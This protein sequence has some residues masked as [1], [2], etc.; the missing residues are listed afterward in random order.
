MGFAGMRTVAPEGTLTSTVYGLIR[1]EKYGEATK[2]LLTQLESF[3]R[4]RAALSLLGYCLYMQADF[5]SAAQCY[6]ELNKFY[7]EVESY[8]LYY[9]QCLHRAGLYPEA[10]KA[11]LRV[12]SEQHAQ[13][14]LQLQAAIKY[15]EDDLAASRTLLEQCVQ[16]DPDT[17]V[18]RSCIA[19]KEGRYDEARAGFAEAMQATGYQPLLAYNVALCH[20]ANKQYGAALKTLGEVIERGVRN[21]PELSVGSATDGVEVRSVGNTPV[22]RETALIEAFNLKAAIEFNM[23][24][25]EAARE[26]LSDMPPRG[27]EELDAVT[28]HNTALVGMEAD[29]TTGFRKLNFLLVSRL[30][31]SC[32]VGR[33][34]LVLVCFSF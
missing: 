32:L 19:Y 10:T 13:R 4:S 22:L 34:G 31:V 24:N 23:K 15:E 30:L 1:E 20:Y 6:E 14:L 2:I 27:E 8:R 18:N 9:A 3:P 21:H 25:L 11:C 16:D 33:V 7:P 5:R 28:L 12:D 26:A 29:P 17:I